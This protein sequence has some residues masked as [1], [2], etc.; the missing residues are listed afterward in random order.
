MYLILFIYTHIYIAITCLH[1]VCLWK[2]LVNW[3]FKLVW[4]NSWFFKRLIWF[5]QMGGESRWIFIVKLCYLF[6]SKVISVSTE[7][8]KTNKNHTCLVKFCIANEKTKIINVR[9]SV[10]CYIFY[11][12][13]SCIYRIFH[14]FGWKEVFKWF[15]KIV[16]IEF[17]II[18][19]LG[20]NF[21]TSWI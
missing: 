1:T 21:Y 9:V 3:R 14:I 16:Q 20:M 4:K 2:E 18:I 12:L 7:A 8:L 13:C 15:F 10:G 11:S 19:V 6:F 5:F 17:F